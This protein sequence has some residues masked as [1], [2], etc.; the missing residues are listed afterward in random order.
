LFNYSL[1]F[2]SG[3]ERHIK[4]ALRGNIGSFRLLEPGSQDLDDCSVVMPPRRPIAAI[5]ARQAA[6][7]HPF[8]EKRDQPRRLRIVNWRESRFKPSKAFDE[9]AHMIGTLSTSCPIR[10]S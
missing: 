10:A 6:P 4:P 1:H 8:L 7:P 3:W 2:R 5:I 9:S